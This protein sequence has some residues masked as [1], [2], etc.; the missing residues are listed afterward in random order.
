MDF[1]SKGTQ[2]SHVIQATNLCED[3]E[4]ENERE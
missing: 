1:K 4:K 2:T 3:T